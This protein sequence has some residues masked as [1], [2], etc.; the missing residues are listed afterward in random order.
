MKVVKKI[1]AICATITI[2]TGSFAGGSDGS[3]RTLYQREAVIIE[4]VPEEEIIICEDDE[5]NIWEFYGEE[6][7]IGKPVSLLMSSNGTE[8][9]RDDIIL[10]VI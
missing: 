8:D 2:S 1:L 4:I 10:K 5:G 7:A 3:G 9:I 6:Y